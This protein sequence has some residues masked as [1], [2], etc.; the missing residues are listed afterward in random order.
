MKR[1]EIPWLIA[2]VLLIALQFLLQYNAAETARKNPTLGVRFAQPLTAEQV[3]AAQEWELS[4]ANTQ[5][6]SA[7]YWGSKDTVVATDLGRRAEKVTAIGYC[8]NAEDCLPT[9]YLQGTAPGVA[10]RQCAISSELAWELFGSYDIVGQE[11]TQDRSRYI[12]SGVFDAQNRMILYPA[13]EG[14]TAAELRETSP[15]TPKGDACQWA[16]SAGLDTPQSIE[17]GPQK[18]WLAKVLCGL[19]T[20]L[21]ML[22]MLV[23][24]LRM[25]RQL[26]KL[27]R[28]LL[29]FALAILAA[30][31]LPP[32]L[33]N[34]P[35]WLIPG[36]WSDFSFWKN[37]WEEIL[38]AGKIS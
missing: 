16:A 36:R 26:P 7:S 15:D 38:A 22:A 29:F 14:F 18:V 6:I 2:A 37:L 12:V 30:L 31:L 4:D 27:L 3:S 11:V 13:Q 8:G 23:I 32:F 34:L 5:G 10:G 25:M 1:R 28:S 19:P 21:V 33:R 20:L 35:G 9:N 17:Y 24:L